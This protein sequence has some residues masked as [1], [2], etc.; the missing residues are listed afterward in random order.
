MRNRAMMHGAQIQNGNSLGSFPAAIATAYRT[1]AGPN[2]KAVPQTMTRLLR[3]TGPDP[4]SAFKVRDVMPRAKPAKKYV[5]RASTRTESG[6]P[7]AHTITGRLL[8]AARPQSPIGTETARPAV[9]HRV[10]SQ[11]S[12]RSSGDEP[13][14]TE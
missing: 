7:R 4:R 13:G 6:S 2:P 3:R 14:K 5:T 1:R 11:G 9:S 8:P 10:L 12:R